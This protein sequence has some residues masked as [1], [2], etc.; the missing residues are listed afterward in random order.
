MAELEAHRRRGP[1]RRKPTK[2]GHKPT[3]FDEFGENEDWRI[4]NQPDK[5]TD[6]K[7]E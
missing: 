7:G 4:G 3:H 2:N 5:P 6:D 1:V